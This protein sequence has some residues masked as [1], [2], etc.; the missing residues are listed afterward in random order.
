MEDLHFTGTAPKA[1]LDVSHYGE[2]PVYGTSLF[3]VEGAPWWPG[4]SGQQRRS[5]SVPSSTSEGIKMSRKFEFVSRRRRRR[6]E[7]LTDYYFWALENLRT[8]L[9]YICERPQRVREKHSSSI[10]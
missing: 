8:R 4:W 5:A 3:S 2:L 7:R 10:P 9:A 6:E 1:Q